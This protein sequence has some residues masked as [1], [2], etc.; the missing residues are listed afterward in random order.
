[1]TRA[2]RTCYR[3]PM[4]K[5]LLLSIL[6]LTFLIPARAARVASPRRALRNLLGSMVLVQL[7]YA[8]FLYFLHARLG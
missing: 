2:G 7:G 5:L 1:M 6:L 4:Q 8:F 3:A